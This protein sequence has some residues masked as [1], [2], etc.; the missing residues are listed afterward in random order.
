MVEDFWK[1][2]QVKQRVEEWKFSFPSS[3][4]QAHISLY[5]PQLFSPFVRLQMLGWNPLEVKEERRKGEGGKGREE[6]RGEGGMCFLEYF[7]PPFPSPS[8]P[9]SLPH[10]LIVLNLSP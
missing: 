5:L 9:P 4:S 10:R 6:G 1:L 8:L 7:T 3:Y 2:S